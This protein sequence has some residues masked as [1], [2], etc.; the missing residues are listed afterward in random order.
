MAMAP[1]PVVSPSRHPTAE[2]P[3]PALGDRADLTTR[4]LSEH[5]DIGDVGERTRVDSPD[6]SAWVGLSPLDETLEKIGMGR[7]Q[8]SL[9]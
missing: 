3:F 7:Y 9:L 2:F 5:D 1:P 6:E 4:L 8:K